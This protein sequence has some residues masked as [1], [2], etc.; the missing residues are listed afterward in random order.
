MLRM[1]G[2]LAAAWLIAAAP[3]QAQSAPACTKY[4]APTGDDRAAG[5]AGAPLRTAQALADALAG[6]GVGCL[7]PGTYEGGIV[8][9]AGGVPHDRL[10]ITSAPAGRASIVGQIE[11]RQHADFVTLQGLRLDGTNGDGGPSPLV[12]SDRKSTRA[13]AA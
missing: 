7:Q 1:L 5:T 6:G 12:N 10:V 4:A 13:M 9:R 11:L 2:L 3:A 8:F